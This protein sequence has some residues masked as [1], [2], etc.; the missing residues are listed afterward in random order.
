MAIGSKNDVHVRKLRKQSPDYFL[1]VFLDPFSAPF[2]DVPGGY[3]GV[4]NGIRG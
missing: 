1:A 4:K 3:R 2:L